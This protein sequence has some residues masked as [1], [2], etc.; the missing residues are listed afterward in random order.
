MK[1][2]I[3]KRIW[4][5]Y[6]IGFGFGVDVGGLDGSRVD[7]GGSGICVVDEV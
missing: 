3:G 5:G 4:C 2:W 6:A 7:V 1:C